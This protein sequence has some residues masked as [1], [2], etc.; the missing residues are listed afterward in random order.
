M[1]KP[2]KR[3]AILRAGVQILHSRGYAAS[4]VESITD[5][6]G[7]AK[8]SFFNHFASKESFLLAVLETYIAAWRGTSAG[9]LSAQELSPREKLARLL[10]AATGVSHQVHDSFNGSLVGNLCAEMSGHTEIRPMLA[11]TLERWAEPF[12]K[13]ITSARNQGLLGASANPDVLA[14]QIVTF[15]QGALLRSRLEQ[16]PAAV[17]E[18]S[19]FVLGL[20]EPRA[21]APMAAL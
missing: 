9:I 11:K 8:G 19:D 2:S 6:A 4:T 16:S 18:F 1:A 21:L 5:A 3:D 17:H 20:L 10:D 14:K 15:L 7:V 13:V 12:V